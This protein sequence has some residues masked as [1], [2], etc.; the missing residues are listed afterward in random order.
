MKHDIVS[1]ETGKGFESSEVFCSQEEGQT[2]STVF[3]LSRR[4]ALL[5]AALCV[6]PAL[7]EA[8]TPTSTPRYALPGPFRGRVVEVFH[9]RVLNGNRIVR[10][11]LREMMAQG[12]MR[13][14]GERSETG[15]WRRFFGPDDVVGIKGCPVGRPHA[16]AHAETLSEVIR[17]LT[18]AG[19]RPQNIVVFERYDNELRLGGYHN[20]LPPGARFA[21]GSPAYDETQLRTAGY[22]GTTIR[23]YDE[24]AFVELPRVVPGANSQKSAHRRSHLLQVVSREVTKV[25][26]VC[27]LKDH[28]ASGLTMALKNMSHG[29]VNNVRRSHAGSN[30]TETFIPA[31]VSLPA[32]RE[33]V[34]LH[35]CD[36]LW[37]V[38]DGGP[39]HWNPNFRSWAYRSFLLATDP[40][41]MD[42]IGWNIL[43]RKRRSAGLPPI[44]DC[45]TGAENPGHEEFTHRQP[46]HVLRAG[47]KGLGEANLDRIAHVRLKLGEG[48]RV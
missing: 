14:T 6:V 39:G 27:A 19:V 29:F 5:A 48:T 26:N 40:V 31:I 8:D 3:A 37:G 43:D 47:R 11:A 1:Q 44:A 30:W 25:I 33:K 41:A 22:S 9:A 10:G 17:G 18:L 24:N 34:V 46:G 42:R 2:E 12:L 28:T 4:E 16:I 23:G 32:I 45:G 38:Y 7:T 35:L 20:I 13:L 21:S 36:A 15:A